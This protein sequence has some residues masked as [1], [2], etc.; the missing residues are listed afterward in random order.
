[1]RKLGM[2]LTVDK[3]WTPT[4]RIT[5]AKAA[6]QLEV[7]VDIPDS[8][9]FDESKVYSIVRAISSRVNLNCDG[10][11]REEI[12]GAVEGHEPHNQKFGYRTFVGKNNHIDHHN[13]PELAEGDPRHAPRGE[14][15][16]AWYVE[17]DFQ[18][19]VLMTGFPDPAAKYLED[20]I[21]KMAGQDCWVKLL[22]AN[23]RR[24]VPVLCE[25]IEKGVVTKVSMGAEIINSSC[26][27]CGNV[28]RHEFEYCMHSRPFNRGFVFPAEETSPLVTAG[29]INRGDPVLAA[30][31]NHG[32]QFFEISWILDVQADPTAVVKDLIKGE[33]GMTLKEIET[34]K[35]DAEVLATLNQKTAIEEEKPKV[36]VKIDGVGLDDLEE[37]EG[38]SDREASPEM[39]YDIPPHEQSGEFYPDYPFPCSA[40]FSAAQANPDYP[41]DVTIDI[42]K[43]IGCMY[44]RSDN[45]GGVDCS[46]PEV[47]REDGSDP[48][49]PGFS[50]P[51]GS[52][53]SKAN[54]EQGSGFKNEDGTEIKEFPGLEHPPGYV[55]SNVKALKN[56][57]R[58]HALE[59]GT[60]TQGDRYTVGLL[61]PADERSV[62]N[63]VLSTMA[64]RFGGAN[65]VEAIDHN[66][67]SIKRAHVFAHTGDPEDATRFIT[68][69]AR[70][71]EMFLE[72]GPV[73]RTISRNHLSSE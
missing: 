62:V 36:N 13:Q 19:P 60:R 6:E 23:D 15:L 28:A 17:E 7:D 46:F 49:P 61:V 32:L 33:P 47:V 39:D 50:G 54:S 5:A 20:P 31:D 3:V 21:A 63:A 71:L 22:I 26:T 70:T 14:I 48:L 64:H 37:E 67:P 1:M 34:A 72:E 68:K 40:L 57:L 8:L 44:N 9:V 55:Q 10:F 53:G 66:S 59:E 2:N 24:K 41:L 12:L 45:V 30:E 4:R 73:E 11:R 56:A 65:S 58:K 35:R 18:E 29:V 51:G 27:V 25:A 38:T 69:L 52:D 42:E 43:C 16:H